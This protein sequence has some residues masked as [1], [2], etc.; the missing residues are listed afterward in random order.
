MRFDETFKQAIL[1][2]ALY[3]VQTLACQPSSTLNPVWPGLKFKL[4]IKRVFHYDC[5]PCTVFCFWETLTKLSVT[6]FISKQG[7]LKLKMSEWTKYFMNPRRQKTL[8]VISLEFSR[9]RFVTFVNV[10]WFILPYCYYILVLSLDHLRTS[11][12]FLKVALWLKLM[13]WIWTQF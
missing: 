8:N 10:F 7:D 6:Y 2:N 4:K 1:Q 5:F 13:Y 9:T 11:Q 3:L 12:V